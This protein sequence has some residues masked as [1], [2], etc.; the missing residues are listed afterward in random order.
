MIKFGVI[1]MGYALD[2]A[3]FDMPRTMLFQPWVDVPRITFG[4]DA[5]FRRDYW[6]GLKL[7]S[8]F[9]AYTIAYSPDPSFPYSFFSGSSTPVAAEPPISR[10]ALSSNIS[11]AR[12][13]APAARRANAIQLAVNP[14]LLLEDGAISRSTV[15]TWPTSP[16][17]CPRSCRPRPPG[18]RCSVVTK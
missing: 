12:I 1:S 5:D 7:L 2:P 11:M 15:L 14:L 8:T 17:T 4:S 3:L 10:P 13:T 6:L 16:R 9:S 18:S